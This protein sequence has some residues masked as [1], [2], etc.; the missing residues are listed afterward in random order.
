MMDIKQEE[1]DKR[2]VDG[3]IRVETIVS[4]MKVLSNIEFEEFCRQT[5]ELLQ[6]EIGPERLAKF[7]GKFNVTT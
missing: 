3:V 1:L 2:F 4:N 6:T 5:H 7:Q